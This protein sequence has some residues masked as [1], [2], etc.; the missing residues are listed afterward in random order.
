MSCDGEGGSKE[1]VG[2]VE[3]VRVEEERGGGGMEGGGG[4]MVE[5]RG[6][7]GMEGGGRMAEEGGGR[8]EQLRAAMLSWLRGRGWERARN[9]AS[10]CSVVER[11]NMTTPTSHCLLPPLSTGERLMVFISTVQ[12]PWLPQEWASLM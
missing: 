10:S 6:G 2:E 9:E 11:G 8:R 12:F 3:V 1:G 5:E 7:G 4:G